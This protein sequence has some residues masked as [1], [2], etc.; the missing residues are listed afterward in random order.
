MYRGLLSI[1]LLAVSASVH[2]QEG[3]NI[4]DF[5]LPGWFCP[6]GN[7][8]IWCGDRPVTCEDMFGLPGTSVIYP[9]TTSDP[10]TAVGI[11]QVEVEITYLESDTEAIGI[12]AYTTTPT[13]PVAWLVCQ[14]G[15]GLESLPYK[16]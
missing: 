9:N 1:W 11:E 16:T 14:I 10:Q 2:A 13:V 4:C 8:C 7:S 3:E 15:P 6:D 12:D 5:G